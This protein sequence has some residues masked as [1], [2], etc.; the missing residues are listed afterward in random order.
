MDSETRKILVIDI[1]WAPAL[2]Y[3]WRM[4][5]ENISPEQLIDHGGMLCFCAHWYGSKEYFFYS[6]W[7]HGRTGMA[8]AAL[9]L[10]E[11][12]DAV[13]TYN[14][15]KYD[16]PKIT[17]EIMLAGLSPPPKVANIDLIRT[18]KK[19]G[20]NM[21]RLAYIGP[22]LKL[23]GKEKHH[24]FA[25]WKEV[26]AGDP[27]AQ[28]K[29]TKYCIRDVKL[30]AKLYKRVLPFITD[31]PAI[32]CGDACPNCGSHKTQKRGPRYTRYFRIQRN[33]CQ[34]CGTWFETTRQKIK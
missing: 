18:I 11:Q 28:A 26:L 16:I 31:H 8:Q 2:A 33:Q 24:G 25:L 15:I 17:G 9:E 27:K 30:T 13:V 12:A 7:E 6:Q 14:G 10:F 4:W 34:S 1:E 19:M 29:M 21:N 32:R 5:D 23:G 20:F 22:L 3:V